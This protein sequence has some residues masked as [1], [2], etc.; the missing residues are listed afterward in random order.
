MTL[1]LF[2][3]RD[4]VQDYGNIAVF[5]QDL[6]LACEGILKKK[7]KTTSLSY[8]ERQTID[9]RLWS[10]LQRSNNKNDYSTHV[11]VTITATVNYHYV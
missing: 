1:T 3:E 10:N 11:H 8:K 7:K 2:A 9:I 4:D 6:Y 5:F